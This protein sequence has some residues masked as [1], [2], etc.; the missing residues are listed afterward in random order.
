MNKGIKPKIGILHNVYT[1]LATVL[2]VYLLI[3]L[4]YT[5]EILKEEVGIKYE[6]SI[7]IDSLLNERNNYEIEQLEGM[8]H[9]NESNDK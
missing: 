1:I 6:Y 4:R 8:R 2:C 3:E 5:N 7:I 9:P